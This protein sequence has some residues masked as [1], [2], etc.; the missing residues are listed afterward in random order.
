MGRL[1]SR[2]LDRIEDV[3]YD[4]LHHRVNLSKME[5][6]RVTAQTWLVSQLNRRRSNPA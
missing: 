2:V 6:V 5:K 3:D 1:Y 4:V